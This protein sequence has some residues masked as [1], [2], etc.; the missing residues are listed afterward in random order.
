MV[1][2]CLSIGKMKINILINRGNEIK[3]I[4]HSIF[5]RLWLLVEI[6]IGLTLTKL[7]IMK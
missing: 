2:N 5:I 3:T 6:L 7:R 1:K 4:I